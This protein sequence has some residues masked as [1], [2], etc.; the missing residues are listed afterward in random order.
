M[1]HWAR[2]ATIV[3]FALLGV[4]DLTP[5]ILRRHDRDDARYLA[6]GER[7]GASVCAV[8]SAA[9]TLVGDRWIL[10]AGHVAA[11]ISPFS[12]SAQCGGRSFAIAEVYTY[13]GWVMK[14]ASG[15]DELDLEI[16]DL[17]LVRLATPATGVPIVRLHRA[18]GEPGRRIIVVGNG[19]SGTGESGPETED[20]RLRAATNVIDSVFGQYFT[21]TFSPPDDPGATDL[22]GIGG[23]GDSGGPAFIVRRGRLYVA[24]VS[25]LN[26]RGDAAGPSRYR[27]TELYARVSPNAAWID[28]VMAGRGTPD[29]VTD[30]AR[31][32]AAGWPATAG[33]ETA[34]RWL[35]AFNAQDS[36]EITRFEHAFRADS[37]LAKRSADERVAGWRSL[38]A[39]WGALE[40]W[41][42][43]ES[44]GSPFLLLVHSKKLDRWMSLG[45]RLEPT[46]PHKLVGLRIRQPE[47]APAPAAPGG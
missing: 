1:H 24:G 39:D 8:G 37:L 40:A 20:G 36:V 32:L 41:G 13:P 12:R 16:P 2:L 44:P 25:S 22:E 38:F 11:N 46:A 3:P 29:A 31:T 43:A 4:A 47:D 28:R 15:G 17:A 35:E 19:L 33:G 45:F 18:G 21:F 14:R 9:G 26:H 6:A 10:T 7:W 42:Y 27:S 30:T 5:P 34:R 23:P